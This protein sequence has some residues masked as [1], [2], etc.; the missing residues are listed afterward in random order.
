MP[1]C[2]SGPPRGGEGRRCGRL[3][4][5]AARTRSTVVPSRD[6]LCRQAD[7]R[8]RRHKIA[9][10]VGRRW[11]GISLAMRAVEAGRAKPRPSFVLG[12]FLVAWWAPGA[13]AKLST[14]PAPP[15][16]TNERLGM[17]VCLRAEMIPWTMRCIV[18][19]TD[20]RP[21][22]CEGESG[23]EA[24]G[25][26]VFALRAEALGNL[27]MPSAAAA[28]R[29]LDR[30][31][32]PWL[33]RWAGMR[34]RP[35]APRP[36]FSGRGLPYDACA[37]GP[38]GAPSCA[39]PVADGLSA[40]ALPVGDAAEL[41][42]AAGVR[43]CSRL[44]GLAWEGGSSGRA[45]PPRRA[46]VSLGVLT[47]RSDRRQTLHNMPFE[48]RS[49]EAPSERW[50]A[51][52]A[53]FQFLSAE[54]RDLATLDVEA[55]AGS[56]EGI[57]EESTPRYTTSVVVLRSSPILTGLSNAAMIVAADAVRAAA[58][59]STARQLGNRSR[60][61]G[62]Q[63]VPINASPM[64]GS[65][66][67]DLLP[68]LSRSDAFLDGMHPGH[69]RRAPSHGLDLEDC[70]TDTW[71]DS[72]CR[73]ALA[74]Q[75][76][77]APLAVSPSGTGAPARAVRAAMAA[78][79]DWVEAL[80]SQREMHNDARLPA[81]CRLG[82]GRRGGADPTWHCKLEEGDGSR[83]LDRLCTAPSVL[84]VAETVA[85]SWAHWRQA[86]MEALAAHC[87]NLA[88]VAATQLIVVVTDATMFFPVYIPEAQT[89]DPLVL[90]AAASLRPSASARRLAAALLGQCHNDTDGG[91]TR[92]GL[93]V[94]PRI[95]QDWQAHCELGQGRACGST[96][97]VARKA[98][99]LLQQLA[100]SGETLTACA[101]IAAD[102]AA[103]PPGAVA[104]MQAQI[105]ARLAEASI[106]WVTDS[107]AGTQAEAR[108]YGQTALL[109][110]AVLERARH[111]TTGRGCGLDIVYS[112]AAARDAWLAETATLAAGITFSS[113]DNLVA[114]RRAA[115]G[116]RSL[117][118]TLTPT[119]VAL[120]ALLRRA[121]QSDPPACHQAAA[122][123]SGMT[124]LNADR[125]DA[126]TGQSPFPSRQIRLA[127]GHS[128]KQAID[129]L[130]QLSARLFAPVEASK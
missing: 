80:V 60:G 73:W 58:L 81:A 111:C 59:A 11:A 25:R 47:L 102:L 56:A 87:G 113:M 104:A 3:V 8:R 6:W 18:K 19:A 79:D 5:P 120:A 84:L 10:L 71:D 29:L 93:L 24:T 128:V 1:T 54:E 72:R 13:A 108:A 109:S 36:S 15:C 89:P 82:F 43:V 61:P 7:A 94:H 35:A 32:R 63:W 127:C 27:S 86:P 70:T 9:R 23:H 50:R 52:L 114:T 129:T 55:A 45:S 31:A 62:G 97:V 26:V 110:T 34:R 130:E 53:P 116:L 123:A 88:N 100:P 91:A 121:R 28:W 48:L 20:W 12:L 37:I 30:Q 49:K 119:Q 101:R 117:C 57:A 106:R 67:G 105:G 75:V 41:L 4:A 122:V 33:Q 98:S 14:L 17:R 65:D 95:E 112:M 44:L 115:R 39:A 85:G 64:V 124:R 107:W 103:S 92:L 22:G 83:E 125:H 69:E 38:D 126:C 16:T 99:V 21:T 2:A 77:S 76:D 78:A 118:P 96:S 74:S 42:V 68:T 51:Q 46:T 66:L 90:A 40:R